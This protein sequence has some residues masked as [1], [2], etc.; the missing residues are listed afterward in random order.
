MA[1][2]FN[3]NELE[4]LEKNQIDMDPKLTENDTDLNKKSNMGAPS[5]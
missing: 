4:Q 2:D 3:K 1:S 5:N